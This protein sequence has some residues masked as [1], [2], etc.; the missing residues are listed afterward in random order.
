MSDYMNYL[1]ESTNTVKS[2][3][4]LSII[5]LLSVYLGIWAFSILFFWFFVGGSDAFDY[6]FM[7]LWIL[8]PVTTLVISFLIGISD[9]RGHWKW[10]S[11]AVFGVMYML[12]EYATFKT[13]NML[14]FGKIKLPN[15]EMLIAG[16]IISAIG[17][18][19]GTALGRRKS[20]Y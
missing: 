3:K 5:I 11:A 15:F 19:I 7:F 12:A 20:K 6:Y 1:E 10:L 13:A 18:G 14:E 8:L 9:Y 2:K 4:R 16:V 17:L